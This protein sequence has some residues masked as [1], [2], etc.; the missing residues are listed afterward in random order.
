[1]LDVHRLVVL[2]EIG[3]R[4]SMTA[5]ARALRYSHSAI[6]QQMRILEKE[7]G[8]VL[9]ER[10][11][12]GVRLTD[13]AQQ[14]V[15]HTEEVMS[16][17]ERAESDLASADVEIRGSLRIAAFSSAARVAVPGTLA[18]LRE[19]H[20]ALRVDFEEHE[21]EAGLSLLA[22]RRI[23][24]LVVDEYPGATLPVGPAFH[25]ELICRDPIGV[26]LPTGVHAGT[27]ADLERLAWV[28]EPT[29]T[30]A[31]SWSL[32]LCRE[33]GFEPQVRYLSADLLL[34]LR[35]V[36]AEVAAAFLPGLLLGETGSV[37]ER[38]RLFPDELHRG[39]LAVC[40]EGSQERPAI[41][42][43]RQVIAEVLIR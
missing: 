43:G 30:G 18:R 21:P 8:A 25:S 35:M 27:V 19:L 28:M 3:V 42:A 22:A 41:R 1:V 23:D 32:R 2:R 9:L 40:R 7:T 16:I 37:L 12:R 39:I 33:L 36:E 15:R 4:G 29:G 31:H 20:P 13:A 17:L 34:H 11:G 14:L 10:V 26:F 24:L 6:S 38:S 5:A